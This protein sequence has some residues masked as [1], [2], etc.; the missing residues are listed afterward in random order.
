MHLVEAEDVGPIEGD[1]PAVTA[2]RPP[3]RR[4]SI[5]LVFTLSVLTGL[6]VAI[7]TLLPARHD[8]IITVAV[9]EHR[10]AEGTWDLTN[11]TSAELRAW[12]IGVV[13]KDVP[14]PADGVTIL[15]ARRIE[16]LH[17]AAALVRVQIGGEP[18][19]VVVQHSR[20]IAPEH[21]ERDEGDLRALAWRRGRFTFVAVGS[22][23]TAATW[24]VAVRR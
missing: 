7:Y 14:L 5:S 4:V 23:A 16:I 18:V 12:A 13:G 20:G 24:S 11:P 10:S 21:V 22:A 9:H 2:P 15:G 6:V 1:A 17:R 19:T 3:H 8:E